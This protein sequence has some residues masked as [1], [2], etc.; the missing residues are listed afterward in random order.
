MNKYQ[1]RLFFKQI[2]VVKRVYLKLIYIYQS[3]L[4]S[5][6]P[7]RLANH[8]YKQ[9]FKKDINWNNPQD[10]IEKTIWMQFNTDTSLWSMCADKY[11]VREYVKQAGEERLLN[12][13]YGCYY[14]A[15]DIDFNQLPDR[16]VLKSNNACGT[17]MLVKDKSKIDIFR[18]KKKML[19]WLN[20]KYGIINA[21]LHYLKIKPCIIAE[22]LLTDDMH[23]SL[24]DYKFHCI[25][26]VPELVLV[27]SE[28]NVESHVYNTSMY[29][30][31]WNDV[32]K[33]YCIQQPKYTIEKPLS[34]DTMVE[35]CYNL[36]QNIPYVR[37]DFYDIDGRAYFGE[38]TFTT[39]FGTLT[40][41]FYNYMG[42]KLIIKK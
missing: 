1:V 9:I 35:A 24:I 10:L 14:S 17:V 23:D 33:I 13:I 15:D 20:Y 22:E 36:A 21:Q 40:K 42:S 25:N 26:G 5:K 28:R 6:N 4:F 32:S 27:I 19:N 8:S 30:L 18:T 29:D 2:K 16:F 41:E 38:M 3:Y 37:I 39:G 12:R 34:F 11:L 31:E 7:K